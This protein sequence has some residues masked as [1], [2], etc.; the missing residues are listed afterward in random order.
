MALVSMC[1]SEM[2]DIADI[3]VCSTFLIDKRGL[4]RSDSWLVILQVFVTL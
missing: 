4:T 3:G 2:S 1:L